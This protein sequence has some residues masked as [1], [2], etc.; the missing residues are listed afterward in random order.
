MEDVS[1][2]L[3][4]YRSARADGAT[5]TELV[6][7]A[8][9]AI[10]AYADPALLIGD[11]EDRARSRARLLD[12]GAASNLPLFGVP[13]VV[14]D[15]IDVAGA[16]TSAACPG[17]AFDATRSAPAVARLEAAGAVV[18]GK[19]NMDQFATGLVGVRSPHGTPRN[20]IAPNRVPGGSSSGSGAAVGAGL[21]PLALGTDTAGSGRVPAALCGTVGLKPTRGLVSTAGVVPACR[22][23]DCV[24][25]F[26][27]TVADA[28]AAF[29]LLHG[30]DPADVW[31][32]VDR[33]QRPL[34]R[35]DR[36]RVGVPSDR[37]L[38]DVDDALATAFRADVATL[39]AAGG[40]PI[41]I[42]L[43]PF[44]ATGDLLYGGPWVA[45][46][47]AAVGAFLDAH[48]EAVL[49]VTR[50]IIGAGRDWTAAEAAS[51]EVERRTLAQRASAAWQ[52]IDVLAVP[53]IPF[54]P[55]PDEVAADPVGVNLR[56]GRFTMFANLLD[57]AAIA[58]PRPAGPP[59]PPASTTLYG[60][61][62]SDAR[63]VTLAALLVHEQPV[64][65]AGVG[66][67]DLAVVGAHLEGEALHRELLDTGAAFGMRTTT[68]P[69]YRLWH[70][71]GVPERPGLE[72]VGAGGAS[73]EVEV[74][75]VPAA[76]LGRFVAAVKAPLA[77]GTIELV[78]GR[79]VSGFVCEP[80][81]F[82]GAVDIT[83]SGGWR[84]R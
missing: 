11:L 1:R 44:F 3:D 70:L 5:A 12:R 20:P 14:K 6:S 63:L 30:L 16:A 53:T 22:S 55:S 74:W 56:L 58:V 71:A 29:E 42:D 33:H 25:V 32:R 83:V 68:A 76:A 73:I 23:L 31:A 59:G 24:S 45:E 50:G 35:P 10:R 43:A 15:N 64:A 57:L 26:S 80:R 36:L 38:A 60:P 54:A 28:W 75:Q 47:Y 72:H 37:V 61:A 27:M 41:E 8:F 21:V 78:D 48:P 52:D 69:T 84:R 46:R 19:S 13:I 77:I 65:D 4:W 62:C 79:A 49:D 9:A 17:F 67:V 7:G 82:V 40:T 81:G 51:A 39:V 2:N 34:I 66:V 18:V